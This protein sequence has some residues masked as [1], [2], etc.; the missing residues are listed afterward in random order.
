VTIGKVRTATRK[1]TP[2]HTKLSD[3]L[4]SEIMAGKYDPKTPMPTEVALRKRF[5]ASRF[6]VRQALETLVV[7]G[8][9]YRR[10]GSGTFVTSLPR[11]QP[12]VRILGSVEDAMA[13]GD[14]TVFFPEHHLRQENF[15]AAAERLRLA[16]DE[17][18]VLRGTRYLSETPFGYW[19]IHLPPHVG[20]LLG[21][22]FS[23]ME[24]QSTI[25][26]VKEETGTQILRAEQIISA[27]L[28]DDRTSEALDVAVG[29]PVLR[30][31]RLYLDHKDDPL[32]WSVSKYRPDQY[33]YR[34]DLYP[35]AQSRSDLG[36]APSPE[37]PS[38]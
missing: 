1:S 35:Q 11:Q 23:G 31:E 24:C 29:S 12:Y 5:G 17:V 25:G 30:I 14:E 28:A 4:R 16:Q 3:I 26:K 21:E 10:P 15:K 18:W 22:G 6:T 27:E 8:L 38:S 20:E 7:E 34:I 13:I 19:Q 9:I 37:N 33:N 2:I 36:N 32:E